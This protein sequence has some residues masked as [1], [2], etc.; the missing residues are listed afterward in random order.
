MLSLCN[1]QKYVDEY[2][3]ITNKLKI[4]NKEII[5]MFHFHLPNYELLKNDY[6]NPSDLITNQVI[7][8]I[9]MVLNKK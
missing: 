1:Q 4:E 5:E 6:K 8:M 9:F 2:E 7:E 3:N